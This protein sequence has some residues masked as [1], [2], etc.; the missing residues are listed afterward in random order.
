TSRCSITD[1]AAT[2]L[3]GTS[4]LSSLKGGGLR[5]A[6]D[7]VNPLR[8]SPILSTKPGQLQITIPMPP[9]RYPR[10]NQ[11]TGTAKTS[12]SSRPS[13]QLQVRRLSVRSRS[14]VLSRSETRACPTAPRPSAACTAWL[15][16]PSVASIMKFSAEM[17]AS[18]EGES[19]QE[20]PR[21]PGI[22]TRKWL[23]CRESARESP[24]NELWTLPSVQKRCTF[25]TP[26]QLMP[27]GVIRASPAT[28]P[29]PRWEASWAAS[30][31]SGREAKG[32]AVAFCSIA[33][34]ATFAASAAP[35][36]CPTPSTTA[37]TM[38]FPVGIS[39]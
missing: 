2:L 26:A 23:L 6:E 9:T 5:Q 7:P 27:S 25:P 8:P 31:S 19:R 28:A 11:G 36:P 12:V 39:A 24:I 22:P 1:D 10:G 38:P 20:T 35:G 14:A 13:E 32:L 29:L 4:V 37:S 33:P 18:V 30:S 21:H 17:K 34:N 16:R 15:G 3:L